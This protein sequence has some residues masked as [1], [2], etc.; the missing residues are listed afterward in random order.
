M[1][2]KQK[3]LNYKQLAKKK[4]DPHNQK[5]HNIFV[6]KYPSSTMSLSFCYINCR[7]RN[8]NWII[9]IFPDAEINIFFLVQQI[10]Y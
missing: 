1:T 2:N 8:K 10:L 9:T 6:F 5:V 3:V 4:L 7:G